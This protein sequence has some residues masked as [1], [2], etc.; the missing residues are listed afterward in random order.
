MAC[1]LIHTWWEGGGNPH[2]APIR[3]LECFSSKAQEKEPT[4]PVAFAL[5]PISR[6]QRNTVEGNRDASAL[7]PAVP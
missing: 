5:K 1:L 4:C 6:P 2:T 3:P 7:N